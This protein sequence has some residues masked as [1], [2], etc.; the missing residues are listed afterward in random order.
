[1]EQVLQ[2]IQNYYASE[3]AKLI[4]ANAIL[5]Q[6]NQELRQRLEQKGQKDDE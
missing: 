1:M 6:E 5:A 2:Q 4:R 3:I